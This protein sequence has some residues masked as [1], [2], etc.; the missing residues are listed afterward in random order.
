MGM[1]QVLSLIL[2]NPPF[3]CI[4]TIFLNKI[5]DFS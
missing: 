3:P 5:Q 2:E 4:I 1:L